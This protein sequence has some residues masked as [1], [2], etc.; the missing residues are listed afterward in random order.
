ME[1]FYKDLTEKI[2]KH[3]NGWKLHLLKKDNVDLIKLC[4]NKSLII[5]QKKYI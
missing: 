3:G 5:R 1:Q 2:K 4:N